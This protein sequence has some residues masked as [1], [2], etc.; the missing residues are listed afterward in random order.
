MA[1]ILVILCLLCLFNFISTHHPVS[2]DRIFGDSYFQRSQESNEFRSEY[3]MRKIKQD[4]GL[5]VISEGLD[6]LKNLAH[7]MNEVL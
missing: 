7:E 5:N 4:E 2:V 1:W 3:E 6:T